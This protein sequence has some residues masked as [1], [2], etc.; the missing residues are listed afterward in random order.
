MKLLNVPIVHKTLFKNRQTG[1]TFI[2]WMSKQRAYLYAEKRG[3]LL[4]FPS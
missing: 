3:L 1:K 2:I 4:K